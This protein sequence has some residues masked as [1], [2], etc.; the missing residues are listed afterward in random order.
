MI[1]R[2]NLRKWPEIKVIQGGAKPL[3]K[4]TRRARV[5]APDRPDLTDWN[6]PVC[7]KED[8]EFHTEVAVTYRGVLSN[9]VSITLRG[10]KRGHMLICTRCFRMDRKGLHGERGAVALREPGKGWQFIYINNR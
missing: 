8:G 9:G 1:W 6:C 10:A 2:N 3:K 7:M 5:V 4:R